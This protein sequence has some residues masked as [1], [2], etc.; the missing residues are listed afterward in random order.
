VSEAPVQATVVQ[1]TVDRLRHA[2]KYRQ[3][4]AD[5]VLD[6]VRREVAHATSAADL[7]RRARLKLHRAVAGY[8]LTGRPTRLLRGLDEAISCGSEATRAWCRTVLGCHVSTAERL[9][10]LDRLYPTILGLTGA[11]VTIADLACA[12]NPFTVPWLRQVTAA[13]YTG[14]DLN[15]SYV[16]IGAE[17]LAR[18][19]LAATVRHR[20]V[21]VRPEEIRAD[22]ALLLKTYHC[23]DDRTPGA[24]LR[25]V[26]DIA[27]SCVV[28]S[29]PVRTI[30]GRAARFTRP[31]V[32][33]LEVLAGRRHWELRRG[34]LTNEDLVVVVKGDG[35]GPYG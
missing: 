25:L 33:A 27:A 20:D 18:V 8:L 6:I 9:G 34:S 17:F 29:F 13:Q 23:I 21:L 10:D 1:A 4:H 28:V 16:N 3:I 22:V 26:E 15:L 5:T 7:E 30:G 2:P 24:A 31:H 32:E 11:A 35:L 19:D 12:L 14:Y